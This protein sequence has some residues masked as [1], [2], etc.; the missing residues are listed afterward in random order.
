MKT[1]NAC[2][3]IL[4]ALCFLIA[5]ASGDQSCKFTL[6]N[7]SKIGAQEL[8]PGDY[9]LVVDAPK[10]VLTD[11]KTGKSIE[12]EAKVETTDTKVSST[13]V[14]STQVDGANRISEIRIGGTNTKI[15]FE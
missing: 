8:R 10:V 1:Q 5:T 14:H 13:E 3:A 4:L 15:T 2:I 11:L 6:N 9:K 12:L 7:T